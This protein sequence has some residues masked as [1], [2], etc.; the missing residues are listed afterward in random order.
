MKELGIESDQYDNH[1][2]RG[3]A[4]TIGERIIVADDGETLSLMKFDNDL[5]RPEHTFQIIGIP[6]LNDDGEISLSKGLDV[7]ALLCCILILYFL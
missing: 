6:W 5:H 1:A 3:H 4:G 2:R 7:C